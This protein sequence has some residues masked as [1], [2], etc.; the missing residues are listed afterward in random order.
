MKNLI[1]QGKKLSVFFLL[2]T[3]IF[4][5]FFKTLKFTMPFILALLFALLLKMP[6][7]FLTTKL[8]INISLSSLIS[9]FI[10]FSL[11]ISFFILFFISLYYESSA[12]KESLKSFLNTNSYEMQTSLLNLQNWIDKTLYDFQIINIAKN[13]LI[14]SFKEITT[15]LISLGSL[16][17]QKIFL[18]ISF[19]PYT[20]ILFIFTV[21]STYFLTKEI[22]K[23]NF[24][25]LIYN[26]FEINISKKIIDIFYEAKK[27]LSNYL[28]SYLFLIFISFLISLLGFIF[29]DIK[30][31]LLLSFLASLLD[32][33]PILGMPLI[34]FP[35]I[36]F[37]YSIGDFFKA[38]FLLVLFMFIF[39]LRQFLEP[40][41]MA[42]TLG[43]HPLIM[44]VCIF[45]GLQAGGF[46]GILF[47][48]F[49]VLF[50][51][52]LKKVEVL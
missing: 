3:L 2:Y 20:L 26:Y 21:L 31:A 11:I 25:D 35:L 13:F 27:L 14:S 17:V 34:Y 15:I 1:N 46:L 7:K 49:F 38:F 18:F 33:M 23:F 48:L 9:N 12:L 39:L 45:I 43:I 10:F 42:S 44:L 6:T 36:F 5:T 50:F 4:F 41:L 40:K 52:I 32:L 22:V 51:K 16:I 8:K 47:L 28:F 30:Y 24:R 37:Y 29:L 19:L